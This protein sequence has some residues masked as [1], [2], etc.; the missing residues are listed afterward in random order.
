MVADLIPAS[1]PGALFDQ[2]DLVAVLLGPARVHARQHLGPV[3]RFGAAG[4]GV[5]FEVGVVAVGLARQQALQLALGRA[6]PAGS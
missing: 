6:A 1:S 5:D 4:A 3:L 2:L